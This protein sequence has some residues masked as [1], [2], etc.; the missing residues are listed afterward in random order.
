MSR[1]TSL[2]GVQLVEGLLQVEHVLVVAEL[3]V[4]RPILVLRVQRPELVRHVLRGSIA[5]DGMA[6]SLDTAPQES[7]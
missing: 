4:Q 3:V 1:L 5:E 2:V 6:K 7:V